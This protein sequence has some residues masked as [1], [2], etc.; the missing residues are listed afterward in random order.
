MNEIHLLL[1]AVFLFEAFKNPYSARLEN[2][3]GIKRLKSNKSSHSGSH[4]FS[5]KKRYISLRH[6]FPKTLT[7]LQSSQN[8]C[9]MAENMRTIKVKR[10]GGNYPYGPKHASVSKNK[11]CY[12]FNNY[13]HQISSMLSSTLLRNILKRQR[14]S[15]PM[16]TLKNANWKYNKAWCAHCESYWTM[17]IKSKEL[18]ARRGCC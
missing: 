11:I 14:L 1:F 12:V 10:I 15:K 5:N 8:A 9:S 13:S 17:R 2:I 7:L 18:K 4:L 6:R 3:Y 16:S